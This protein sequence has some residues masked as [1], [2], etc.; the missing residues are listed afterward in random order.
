VAW[1]AAFAPG[2]GSSLSFELIFTQLQ[3]ELQKN[4][5]TGMELQNLMNALGGALVRL[6]SI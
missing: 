2:P 3:G 1:V 5:N 6:R 4:K